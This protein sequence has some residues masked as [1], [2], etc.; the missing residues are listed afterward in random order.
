MLKIQVCET[1]KFGF[2]REKKKPSLVLIFY[3]WLLAIAVWNF[4]DNDARRLIGG[5][6]IVRRS[7][8]QVYC[9]YLPTYLR[10]LDNIF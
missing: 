4:H 5:D 9:R 3:N 2:P 10:F 7:F 1:I 8:Y 6:D